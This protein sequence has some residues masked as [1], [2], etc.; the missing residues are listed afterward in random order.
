MIDRTREEGYLNHFKR[1]GRGEESVYQT[2][3]LCHIAD[4]LTS[5]ASGIR[6]LRENAD[7]KGEADD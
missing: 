4:M 7:R 1:F 2:F 3:A 5:I 6:A